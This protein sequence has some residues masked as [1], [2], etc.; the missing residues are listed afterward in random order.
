M[1]QVPPPRNILVHIIEILRGRGTRPLF[2]NISHGNFV[3]GVT[4]VELYFHEFYRTV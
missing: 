2:V 3:N 1:V 4:V